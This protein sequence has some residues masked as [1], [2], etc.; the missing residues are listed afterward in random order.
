M[1]GWNG[2]KSERAMKLGDRLMVTLLQG[3]CRPVAIALFAEETNGSWL[4]FQYDET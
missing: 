1:G 4:Y 3:P 2:Y